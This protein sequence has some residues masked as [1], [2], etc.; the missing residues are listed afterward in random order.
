MSR[1]ID[2]ELAARRVCIIFP[3]DPNLLPVVRSLP[4]RWFDG[5]TKNWY[6]PLEHVD[7][8]IGKLSSHHFKLSPDLRAYC[9]R[10]GRPV[11]EL[12]NSGGQPNNGAGKVPEGT[13][14]ISQLNEEARA[15][16]RDKF[17]DDVWVV[18]EVQSYERNRPGHHAYFELVERLA[19]DEDPVARIR[20]VMFRDDH[21]KVREALANS[22]E[23]IRL[24]DGLAV[25]LQGRVDLYAPHGSYQ[26]IVR[27]VD[28]AYTTGEIHQNRERILEQLEKLGIREDN[29]KLAW[30][31]CPLRVGLITSFES[32][33][34]N[35]FVHELARS[36]LGF[37]V[38]VHDANVQ[39]S[40]TEPSVLRGLNYF[41]ERADDFDVVAIVR[42]GGSR[43]D[44]AYFDTEAIGKAVCAHPLKIITGVGHQRDQCLLDF[45]SDSQKT[46]TAAASAC[47]RRVQEYAEGVEALFE[48]IA[49][50]AAAGA[51]EQMNRLRQASVRL[52]RAVERCLKV[53]TRRLDRVRSEVTYA[54][55]D[56]LVEATRRLDRLQRAIPSVALA[57]LRR[58][59]QSLDFAR[60][61]LSPDRL[62]R[63]L[64]REMSGLDML[65]RRLERLADDTLADQQRRL[66]EH[67]GRLRLLD[68]QRVLERGF[69]IVLTADGVARR[70][71]DVPYDA[72]LEVRLAEGTVTVRRRAEQLE[73]SDDSD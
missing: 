64:Q 61:R 27:G 69:A 6:V 67:R 15:V 51:A 47:V 36:G 70:P 32:D 58:D 50:S 48:R 53:E 8:V 24:R 20:A 44:L 23:T 41:A 4:G 1:L 19:P 26:L 3:Y 73:L 60:R 14:S 9:D 40:Q 28:P 31:R 57:R 21:R 25:R 30:P 54:A 38:T 45:I 39:G 59:R 42:G 63:R 43:S 22:P 29:Q 10:N 16:L 55:K 37:E 11:D 66:A 35:D 65:R 68:P 56:R 2:I 13:Y 7:H 18:G 12:L 62:E 33:A 34:Y 71:E 5:S 72:D 49:E 52:E 46:P 17:A